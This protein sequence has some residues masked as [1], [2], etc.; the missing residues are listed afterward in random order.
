MRAKAHPPA[1]VPH[2]VIGTHLTSVAGGFHRIATPCTKGIDAIA[3]SHVHW[4]SGMTK[5]VGSREAPRLWKTRVMARWA[6][7]TKSSC[8]QGFGN[9]FKCDGRE[10]K[11][12]T[13]ETGHSTAQRMPSQPDICVGVDLSDIGVEINGSSV[14]LVLIIHRLH[15]ASQIGGKRGALT[16]TDLPPEVRASLATAA[17]EKQVVICLVVGGGAS[18]VKES[19]GSAFQ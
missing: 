3:G 17:T 12:Q 1:F 6:G 11:G 14:I 2:R 15:D 9:C 5:V 19:R 4:I 7:N 16:V 18:P 13:Q 8:G 10:A